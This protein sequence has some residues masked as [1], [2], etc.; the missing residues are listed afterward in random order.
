MILYFFIYISS[1]CRVRERAMHAVNI[2]WDKGLHMPELEAGSQLVELSRRRRR[3]KKEKR[4]LFP[5]LRSAG[6]SK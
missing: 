4:K 3:K 6:A 2:H 5:L 1:N